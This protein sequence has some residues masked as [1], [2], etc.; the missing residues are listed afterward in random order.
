M[1]ITDVPS[2][3]TG[4]RTLPPKGP[5]HDRQLLRTVD[6]VGA[7]EAASALAAAAK[8]KGKDRGV[9]AAALTAA[10]P[11]LAGAPLA[12]DDPTRDQLRDAVSS[13]EFRTLLPGWV[14][15]LRELASKRSGSGA[16]TVA[17]AL[18]LW[19]WTI[20]HAD[21]DSADELAVALVPL[22]AARYLTLDTTAKKSDDFRRDVANAHSARVSA[23]LAATCA[24][25]VFGCRRHLTWDAEGC[26]SCYGGDEIDA[27]EGFIPGIAS[28]ARSR[29]DVVESD[30]SHEAKEG[31]CARFEGLERFQQ[32]RNKLDGC[33]TGA[34]LARGRAAAAIAKSVATATPSKQTKG[35]A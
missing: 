19:S 4:L 21:A 29:G 5:A 13:A 9:L 24:E 30:G 12:A 28:G 16:C 31:P 1:P 35:R 27:L 22:L 17:S 2:L 33:L 26:A 6:S 14:H 34:R 20:D 8:R 11:I 10:A 15:E 18:E 23:Q 3:A 32:L 7:T 25:I